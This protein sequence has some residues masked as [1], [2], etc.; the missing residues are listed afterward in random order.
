MSLP[1]I[2]RTLASEMSLIQWLYC[3]H[4][5]VEGRTR[6]V[7]RCPRAVPSA[8][9]I[10]ISIPVQLRSCR[11]GK[12]NDPP[13]VGKLHRL[14]QIL[15]LAESV[16]LSLRL[17]PPDNTAHS[18]WFCLRARREGVYY[19]YLLKERGRV[20]RSHPKFQRLHNK[21]VWITDQLSSG[22]LR[23]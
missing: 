16:P 12:G 9:S 15:C 21:V 19:T 2:C 11:G 6:T 7:H 14:C 18:F 1:G 3:S 22:V 10:P 20:S 17:F 23:F 8:H 13:A 4:C 5:S